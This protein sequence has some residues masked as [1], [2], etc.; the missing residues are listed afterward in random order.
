M[1]AEAEKLWAD[2]K[3]EP[4]EVIIDIKGRK[5]IKC[6]TK[7]KPAA[8]PAPDDEDPD[9]VCDKK[10]PKECKSA[11]T[12]KK[13]VQADPKPPKEDKKKDKDGKD[14]KDD[15]APAKAAAPGLYKNVTANMT[16]NK[17]SNVSGN[18]T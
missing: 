9:C 4:T 15:K 18:V 11:T 13:C 2:G 14:A 16:G 6:K 3:T 1:T 5:Y 7:V 17:T 10:K 8:P 12:G